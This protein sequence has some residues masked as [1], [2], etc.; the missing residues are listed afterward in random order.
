MTY[1]AASVA[2]YNHD[3]DLYFRDVIYWSKISL[4]H[5]K[6]RQ[7]VENMTDVFCGLSDLLSQSLYQRFLR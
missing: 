1:L 6:I 7:A 3:Y 2:T 5:K 4:K